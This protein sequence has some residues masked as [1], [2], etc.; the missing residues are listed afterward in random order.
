MRSVEKLLAILI[1]CEEAKINGIRRKAVRKEKPTSFT[2]RINGKPSGDGRFGV[3]NLLVQ[4]RRTRW[5]YFKWLISET[6][7]LEG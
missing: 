3:I 1:Y 7:V 2:S 5:E 6:T 4:S